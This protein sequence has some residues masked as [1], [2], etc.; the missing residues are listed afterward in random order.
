MREQMA[1]LNFRGGIHDLV[2]QP[3]D[4]EA[5]T[6][7]LLIRFDMDVRRAAFEGVGQDQIH[8]THYGCFVR[9]VLEILDVEIFLLLEDLERG[10]LD[11]GKILHH[12]F[13]SIE[14][15]VP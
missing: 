1:S 3:V 14:W 5:N 9:G 13:S 11:R 2:Q 4:P 12:L 6:E 15:L 8:Q 7:G 10:F